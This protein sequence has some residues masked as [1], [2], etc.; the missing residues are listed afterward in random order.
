MTIAEAAES[1]A[2]DYV[3]YQVELDDEARE[4]AAH[5]AT[6]T[7]GVLRNYARIAYRAAKA[8][9]ANPDSPVRPCPICCGVN[10]CDWAAHRQRFDR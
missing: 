9:K 8:E 6:L 4:T 10:V 5:G 7:A 2:V 1:A 3:L